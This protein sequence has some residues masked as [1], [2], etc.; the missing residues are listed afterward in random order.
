MIV[1]IE[2]NLLKWQK[3]TDNSLTWIDISNI[4]NNLDYTNLTDTTVY[5]AIVN[6]GNC[7]N[8]TSNSQTI[9]IYPKPISGFSYLQVC[10][11]SLTIFNDTST[12]SSGQKSKVMIINF[13]LFVEA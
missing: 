5:R 7:I 11:G 3:S 8:D 6:S 1:L 13:S 4:T 9:S 12:I 2:Q 10:Q